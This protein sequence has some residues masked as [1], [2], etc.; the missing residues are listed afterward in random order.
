MSV[1]CSTSKAVTRSIKTGAGCRRPRAGFSPLANRSERRVRDHHDRELRLR[2]HVEETELHAVHLVADVDETKL[3]AARLV[4]H[5]EKSKP[6][7]VELARVVD[8]PADRAAGELGLVGVDEAD[9]K[10]VGLQLVPV[11][12]AAELKPGKGGVVVD[13]TGLKTDR[14]A[15][16]DV[17]ETGLKRDHAAERDIRQR[18]A[19]DTVDVAIGPGNRRG[20]NAGEIPRAH[21][22]QTRVNAVD[23]VVGAEEPADAD[24]VDVAVR[25]RQL[26]GRGDAD[27]ERGPGPDAIVGAGSRVETDS[28]HKAD[29][30]CNRGFLHVCSPS[31]GVEEFEMPSP[32]IAAGASPAAPSQTETLTRHKVNQ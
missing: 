18:P 25:K 12:D 3:A 31:F 11:D 30:K 17:V 14:I 15:P 21:L 32:P 22:R 29:H 20:L 19:L 24:A 6:E 28:G 7:T 26:D 27:A 9:L 8:E 16:V 13:E 1:E 10:S 2:D 23:V 5:I 4:G